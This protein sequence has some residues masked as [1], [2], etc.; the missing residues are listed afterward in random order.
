MSI[1]IAWAPLVP[2][3]PA[4][5]VWVAVT[6]YVPVAESAVAKVNVQAPA[7]QGAGPVCGLASVAAPESVEL[8]PEA[9]PHAPLTDVAVTLVV[10]GKV[11]TVPFTEVRLTTG[12]VVSRLIVCAPLAPVLPAASF[13]VA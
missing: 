7:L 5:S 8:S 3:L 12:A 2:V 11:R 10:Y 6:L 13:W 9:V 4:V 1:V